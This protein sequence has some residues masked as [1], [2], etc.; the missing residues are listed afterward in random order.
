[1]AEVELLGHKVDVPGG[2]T[3]LLLIAGG[4]V[5]VIAIASRRS[6]APPP[7]SMVAGFATPPG[8]DQ[9]DEFQRIA[10]SARSELEQLTAANKLE[11]KRIAAQQMLARMDYKYRKQESKR[12]SQLYQRT[13]ISWARWYDIGGQDS[14]AVKVAY[15]QA[16]QGKLVVQPT[17]K[18]VCFLPTQVGDRGHLP[19][20]ESYSKSGF[21]SSGAGYSAVPEAGQVNVPSAPGTG[22]GQLMA[23]VLAYFAAT[24]GGGF[25]S[26]GYYGG[27]YGGGGGGYGGGGYDPGYIWT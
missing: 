23:A 7:A 9:N 18:G 11:Y 6:S 5:L 21:F 22:F 8:S 24:N 25:P 27:G 26:G 20:T 4:A 14:S 13:C 12:S 1:M 16:K 3:G 10:L 2:Q 19:P 17:S 15:E